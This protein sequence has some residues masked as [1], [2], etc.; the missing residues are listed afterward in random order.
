VID[1]VMGDGDED[2][3]LNVRF[4]EQGIESSGKT[5]PLVKSE[6]KGAAGDDESFW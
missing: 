6:K 2:T 5:M 3:R 4:Y 1:D